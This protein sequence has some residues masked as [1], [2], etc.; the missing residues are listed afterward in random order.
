MQRTGTVDENKSD[1]V[2]TGRNE[3]QNKSPI[4]GGEAT[5]DG[6]I[7]ADASLLD[8]QSPHRFN[9]AS[10]VNTQAVYRAGW[11]FVGRFLAASEL[12]GGRRRPVRGRNSRRTRMVLR[13]AFR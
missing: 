11:T 7:G 9:T 2:G 6:P 8:G 4:E 13:Y 3:D 12:R 5:H 1:D 10:S